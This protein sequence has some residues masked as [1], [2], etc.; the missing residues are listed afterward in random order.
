MDSFLKHSMVQSARDIFF[1]SL[2]RPL[3][4]TLKGRINKRVLLIEDKVLEEENVP[5]GG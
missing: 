3:S 4:T 1:F 5:N 2:T